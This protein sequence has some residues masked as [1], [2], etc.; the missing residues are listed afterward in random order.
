MGLIDKKSFRN[1]DLALSNGLYKYLYVLI[2]PTGASL[3]CVLHLQF[4]LNFILASVNIPSLWVSS[5]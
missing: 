3:K 2:D 4:P 1:I 5:M